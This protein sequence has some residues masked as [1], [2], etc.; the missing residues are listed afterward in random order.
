[1]FRD[2]AIIERKLKGDCLKVVDHLKQITRRALD[3]IME[4][5]NERFEI[6]KHHYIPQKWSKKDIEIVAR[7]ADFDCR[8][9]LIL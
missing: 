4:I 6:T 3:I 9:K 2:A 7:E 1:M 5:T 8:I